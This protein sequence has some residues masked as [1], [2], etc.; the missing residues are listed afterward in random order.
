MTL[1]QQMRFWA[2]AL[3]AVLFLLWL[4]ADILLPF[5]AGMA[6]AYLLDPVADRLERHGVPRLAA[7]LLILTVFAAFF[8]ILLVALVPVLVSQL[9]SFILRFPEYSDRLKVLF[10]QWSQGWVGRLLQ[11]GSQKIESNIGTILQNLASWVGSFA[12][13]L[14]SG[15]M[16]VVNMVAL[17]VVTPVVAF[18]L[19]VDWD[20][21]ISRLDDL[22]PRNHKQEIRRIMGEIDEA[23]SG[24]IRGQTMVC[25]ILG[26]FYAIGLTLIGLN[27]GL[28]IG[29]VAGL[30][31]FIP[32]VGSI[33]GFI[34]AVTVA[35][36]QFWPDWTYVA[37]TAVVFI[38]G[39]TIEGNIL[40]PKLVGDHVGLHPVW[41]MF[42]LFAFGYLFGFVG[43]LLAVPV[44]A[45]LGVIVRF[46]VA[47]YQQSALYYGTSATQDSED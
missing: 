30:I 43:M 28:L 27:F 38:A 12:K 31:S 35:L 5:V 22:L 4:F 26:G 20:N 3:A 42:A 34:V 21:M 1:N 39:Q 45:A 11:D 6:L 32:Y 29:L 40:Q 7:T 16:A 14:L 44:A 18:Y 41:L 9:D 17:L 25:A 19:L 36:V 24:F 10:D 33:S 46:S 8:I 23:L 15:G 37:L 2:A 47:K 13:S